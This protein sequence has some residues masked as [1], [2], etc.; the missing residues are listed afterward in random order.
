M[1][2]ISVTPSIGFTASVTSSASVSAS[3]STTPAS[4]TVTPSRSA[5]VTPLLRV[6]SGYASAGNAAWITGTG[7]LPAVL[8][9]AKAFQAGSIFYTAVLPVDAF[10][11]QFT[12]KIDTT[13][14]SGVVGDGVTFVI[15]RSPAG[16][17]AVGALGAGLGYAGIAKS[18]AIRFDTYNGA[19]CIHP[20]V[21]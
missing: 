5:A 20:R 15:H 1:P 3:P 21:S 10:S 13:P 12:F 7:N 2:S 14:A 4:A 8:T 19:L 9:N 6:G 11:A 16:V 18:F 17:G